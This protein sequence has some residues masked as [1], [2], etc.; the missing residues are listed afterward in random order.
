METL[1]KELNIQQ[2]KLLIEDNKKKR[3]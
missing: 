1:K 3:H 2:D